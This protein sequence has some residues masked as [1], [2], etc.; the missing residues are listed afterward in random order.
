MAVEEKSTGTAAGL[1]LLFGGG[2]FY[3]RNYGLGV[4]NLLFWPL[5]ICWDP[6]SGTNG[7]ENINYYATKEHVRQLKKKDIKVLD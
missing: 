7:A 1:G 2:S 6:V 4:V 5:S 3:T